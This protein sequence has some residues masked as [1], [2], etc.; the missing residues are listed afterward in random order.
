MKLITPAGVAILLF[1]VSVH[2][3]PLSHPSGTA[4]VPVTKFD[5]ARNADLDI[6][7]AILEARKTDRRILLDVGGDWC[8]WCRRL[9]TLFATNDALRTFRDMHF[10]TVKVN[11]SKENKNTDVLSRYPPI[12]G[13]PHLF[14]LD[15]NGGLLHSQDTGLLESGKSHDPMKVRAFLRDWAAPLTH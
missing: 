3:Q 14:V 5:P 13:Y 15:K 9:D 11:W 1:A 10:V 2:A 12:P 4:Y 8:V 6:R 7:E